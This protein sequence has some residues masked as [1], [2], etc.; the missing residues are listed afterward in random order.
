MVARITP[1][2]LTLPVADCDRLIEIPDITLRDGDASYDVTIWAYVTKRGLVQ[3][4][5][6]GI[7]TLEDPEY[8]VIAIEDMDAEDPQRSNIVHRFATRD[9]MSYVRGFV[10]SVIDDM[11]YEARETQDSNGAYC[12]DLDSA[13]EPM[14]MYDT[15]AARAYD[16]A[17]FIYREV[18]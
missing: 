4:A 9:L 1:D 11:E 12:V 18:M 13:A 8:I 3:I 2:G 10:L 6:D 5:S 15:L 14:P 17:L 16:E 7:T